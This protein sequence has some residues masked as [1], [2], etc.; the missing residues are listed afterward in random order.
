MV[1]AH[2]PGFFLALQSTRPLPAY[3]FGRVNLPPVDMVAV[4]SDARQKQFAWSD[5][6]ELNVSSTIPWEQRVHYYPSARL[7]VTLA[8]DERL[9]LRR[10]PR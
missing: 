1:P 7:L 5:C 4:Y 8:D 2:E 10:A 3:T 9:I 6:K